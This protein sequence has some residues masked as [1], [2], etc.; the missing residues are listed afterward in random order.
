MAVHQVSSFEHVSMFGYTENMTQKLAKKKN[1]RLMADGIPTNSLAA[2]VN[3]I[4]EI[5]LLL[6]KYSVDV[7]NPS[8]PDFK[9]DAPEACTHSRQPSSS[10][11]LSFSSAIGAVLPNT[12]TWKQAYVADPKCRIIMDLITNPFLVV[13]VKLAKINSSYHG[14]LHHG[15]IVLESKILIIKE[16]IKH[17][18][19]Y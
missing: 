18:S 17:K 8:T 2:I 4:F 14:T 1:W 3:C 6:R 10:S 16:P 7:F 15:L 5:L 13:K 11:S 12:Q 9:L 19:T